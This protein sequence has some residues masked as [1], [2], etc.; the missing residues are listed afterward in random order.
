MGKA[1]EIRGSLLA[2]NAALNLLGQT[3]PLLVGVITIPYVIRGLGTE[4][5]GI[6]SIAWVLLG[7]FS[8]VDLG[9]GRAMAKFV[10][11]YLGRNELDKIPG[12]IWTSLGLQ[13]LLGVGGGAFI[14]AM[15]PTL[16]EKIL[17]TPHHLIVETKWAFL[18]LALSLPVVLASGALRGVLEAAQRFDLV[19]YVRV[20]ASTSVFLLPAISVRFGILLPGILG[21][22]LLAKLLSGFVYLLLCFKLFPKL[23]HAISFRPELLRSLVTYGGWVTVSNSISPLMVYMDRF[24]IGSIVSLAA[25]AYY[26]APFDMVARLCFFPESLVAT[27]FPAFSSLDAEGNK[28]RLEEVYARAIKFLL[29]IFEPGLLLVMIFSHDILRLWLGGDFAQKS[30]AVLQILAVGVSINGLAF[31]PYCLL[32]GINRPDLTAKF[33]LLE[34]PISATLM[35]FLVGRMGIAGAALAWTLRVGLDAVLLFG[36]S[37]RLRLV[38]FRG[39]REIGLFQIIK[40]LFLLVLLLMLTVFAISPIVPRALLSVLLVSLF[41]LFAWRYLLDCRERLVLRSLAAKLS[42]VPKTAKS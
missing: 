20:P 35:W 38:S 40:P 17:K 19:F 23:R 6:L 36:A 11:E 31:V 21:L 16:V 32:Q 13:F 37:W 4:R 39:I 34:L 14:A 18:V 1:V 41:A 28:I 30:T 22:L 25:V 7:Y 10:A 9:L 2:G 24:L 15:S 12:L 27:L 26:S 8:I 3:L 5:F 29:I 33:H 42:P